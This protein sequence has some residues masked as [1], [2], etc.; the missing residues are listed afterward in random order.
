MREGKRTDYLKKILH[1]DRTVW[2]EGLPQGWS[3]NEGPIGLYNQS[4]GPPKD[5]HLVPSATAARASDG[6]AGS[7]SQATAPV[8]QKRPP[9]P[10]A[11][12]QK[13]KQKTNEKKAT[14]TKRTYNRSSKKARHAVDKEMEASEKATAG[15]QVASTPS[16]VAARKENDTTYTKD[17][18]EKTFSVVSLEPG[19]LCATLFKGL[20]NQM[21]AT[22]E[23]TI[24][25]AAT[26][27]SIRTMIMGLV[28]ANTDSI[29]S[30]MTVLQD[31]ILSKLLLYPSL[32]ADDI[33]KRKEAFGPIFSSQVFVYHLVLALWSWSDLTTDSIAKLNGTKRAACEAVLAFREKHGRRQPDGP[34]I[35]DPFTQRPKH[36]GSTKFLE[37]C[38]RSVHDLLCSHVLRN[39]SELKKRV[40]V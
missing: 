11:D 9:V 13:K 1:H 32:E 7:S 29:W 17:A 12:Q 40:S 31:F 8:S 4:I 3:K 28:K 22:A 27:K 33:G 19:T 5:R 26:Y 24:H 25:A 34:L 10:E 37:A 14:A 23:G 38:A 35:F 36:S 2:S 39:V 21:E 15:D 30:A 20:Q 16:T 6:Q 18:L